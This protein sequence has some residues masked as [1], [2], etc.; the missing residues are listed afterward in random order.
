M[1]KK[2]YSAPAIFN[3]TINVNG[4]L[5]TIGFNGYNAPDKTRTFTTS[6]EAVQEALESTDA[7][8]KMFSLKYTE[9]T[10][11]AEPV[12]PAPVPEPE[13]EEGK[14]EVKTFV[15]LPQAKK[16]LGEMGKEV[17]PGTKTPQAEKFAA[18]LGFILKFENKKTE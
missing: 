14:L 17:G 18:E 12:K 4:K 13:K 2:L 5:Q 7:F 6:D 11:E 15:N 9:Q 16:W 1:V 8:N 10:Q 3:I